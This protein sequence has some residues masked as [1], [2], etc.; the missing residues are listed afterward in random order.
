[1][2]STE[3]TADSIR[4]VPS[5][6]RAGDPYVWAGEIVDVV[7]TGTSYR[8]LRLIGEGRCCVVFSGETVHS[9]EPV[10]IKIFR[11]GTLYQNAAGRELAVL[12]RLKEGSSSNTVTCLAATS[13]KGHNCFILELLSLNIRQLIAKNNRCGLPLW[14]V[15][16]FA[17]DVLTCLSRLHQERFVHADLKPANILWSSQ[18]GRFKC[19]DFGLSFSLDEK[20]V[21]E[22]QTAGYRSP[23]VAVWNAFKE[24]KIRGKRKLSIAPEEESGRDRAVLPWALE[25]VPVAPGTPADIWSF[26]CLLAEALLGRKL[27][28]AG[29]NQPADSLRPSQLLETR[30]GESMETATASNWPPETSLLLTSIKSLIGRCLTE[31][32]AA[33]ITAAA[34]LHE[35]VQ[36]AEMAAR[37]TRTDNLLLPSPVLLFTLVPSV[38]LWLSAASRAS[39]SSSSS[40]FS[41][42]S[43][44]DQLVSIQELCAQH[45]RVVQTRIGGQT[46][47]GGCQ[48]YVQFLSAQAA[49]RAR[50]LLTRPPPAGATGGA[51]ALATAQKS[52]NCHAAN[53]ETAEPSGS[54]SSGDGDNVKLDTCLNGHNQWTTAVGPPC[55]SS[56]PTP[57]CRPSIV[58]QAGFRSE[59]YPLDLWYK[60]IF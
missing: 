28:R 30:F 11:P 59:F 29:G 56:S 52:F 50:V 10:A 46:T 48:L 36:L 33:R 38:S 23:E 41:S 25:V 49:V 1:M 42:S 45:G 7:E 51:A 12:A 26:G 27:F 60:S 20:D 6:Y 18:D 54:S 9:G 8:I 35:V 39:D 31:D 3:Q 13:F 47:V 19:L 53:D 40:S 43:V 37:P 24:S 2:V 15:L 4:L 34:A 58:Q 17:R 32:P 21:H 16:K 55:V 44:L 57:R 14:T 22:I 5:Y